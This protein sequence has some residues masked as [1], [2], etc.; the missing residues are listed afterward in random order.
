MTG[1]DEELRVCKRCLAP[2]PLK[3][4]FKP[5]PKGYYSRT[6]RQ[7]ESKRWWPNVKDRHNTTLRQRR[8]TH[9]AKYILRDSRKFDKK[10]GFENDL[11]L[12][13]VLQVIAE[14]CRYCGETELRMTLDRIDN[15][16]GHL[17]GNILPACL[18]CNYFRKDMPYEAWIHIVPAIREARARGLFGS[19]TGRARSAR[20]VEQVDTPK[21]PTIPG[22]GKHGGSTPPAST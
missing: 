9:P 19:W 16:R 7:C 1:D 12:E 18:R 22:A 10:K 8:Q 4:K 21:D 6:C 17:M 14:P 20:V 11:T 3:T 5:T 13:F 15:A 2:K